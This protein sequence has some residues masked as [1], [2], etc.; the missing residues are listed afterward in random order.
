MADEEKDI[1]LNFRRDA[2]E[3]LQNPTF[4]KMNVGFRFHMPQRNLHG[5]PHRVALPIER[6][7]VDINEITPPEIRYPV[8]L[9]GDLGQ[10]LEPPLVM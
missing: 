5:Q 8:C 2:I 10:V 4:L 1:A 3:G 7:V 6:R 9:A